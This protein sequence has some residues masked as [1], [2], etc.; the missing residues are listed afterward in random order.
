MTVSDPNF[1]MFKVVLSRTTLLNNLVLDTKKT[2]TIAARCDEILGV[3]RRKYTRIIAK[4]SLKKQCSVEKLA[5]LR[6]TELG[7]VGWILN[8]V[9][10]FYFGD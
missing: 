4:N 6:N 7:S 3:I 5:G 1:Q 10:K 9:D 8:V 2:P